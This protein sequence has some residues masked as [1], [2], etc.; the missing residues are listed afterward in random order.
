[1]PVS[2]SGIEKEDK[3]GGVQPVSSLQP[4]TGN[5]DKNNSGLVEDEQV[6]AKIFEN[7]CDSQIVVV[8]KETSARMLSREKQLLAGNCSGEQ[9]SRGGMRSRIDGTAVSILNQAA[10]IAQFLRTPGW[11]IEAVNFPRYDY[12]VRF[13]P[14]L[15]IGQVAASLTGGNTLQQSPS[16]PACYD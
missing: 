9:D 4:G 15:Q 14:E 6:D 8:M 16:N 12:T 11:P 2:G 5:V 1:M 7:T 13:N 10:A 3:I